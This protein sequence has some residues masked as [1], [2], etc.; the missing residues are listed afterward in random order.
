MKNTGFADF[1]HYHDTQAFSVVEEGIYQALI[2]MGD[3]SAGDYV[4][5]LCF[6]IEE[7]EENA[8]CHYLLEDILDRYNAFAP[9]AEVQ[10]TEFVV[11]F[12]VSDYLRQARL[13]GIDTGEDESLPGIRQLKADLLGARVTHRTVDRE[14]GQFLELTIEK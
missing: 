12:A 10:G 11:E 6:H 5:P 8:N 14:D 9:Y 7:E 2:D 13:A 3:L 4:L 1:D